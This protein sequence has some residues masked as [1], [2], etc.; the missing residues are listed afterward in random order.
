M[1]Q[2]LAS[3]KCFPEDVIIPPSVIQ[4][5]IKKSLP[6]FAQV[7]R[8]EEEPIAFG[9][10]ALIAHILVP[11]SGGDELDKVE[12]VLKGVKGISQVETLLVRRV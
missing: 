11:D 8:I 2:V 6:S 7:Y 10:V 1:A 9:L 5:E 4:E 12:E 3:I